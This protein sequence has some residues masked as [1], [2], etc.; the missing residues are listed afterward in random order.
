MRP[1]EIRFLTTMSHFGAIFSEVT[2]RYPPLWGAIMPGLDPN[3]CVVYAGM[4][5][6]NALKNILRFICILV[7]R[8]FHY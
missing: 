3:L 7:W 8:E 1:G 6:G 4:H 5:L 2:L